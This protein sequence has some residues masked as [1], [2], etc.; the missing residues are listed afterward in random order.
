MGLSRRLRHFERKLKRDASTHE[1]R[2]LRIVFRRHRA[3]QPLWFRGDPNRIQR[4]ARNLLLQDA[5]RSHSESWTGIRPTAISACARSAPGERSRPSTSA[6][7]AGRD[8]RH[9]T[10]G[11]EIGY[12]PDSSRH[13][14]PVVKRRSVSRQGLVSHRSVLRSRRIQPVHPGIATQAMPE[15]KLTH[16][17]RKRSAAAESGAAEFRA[18]TPRSRV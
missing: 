6:K 10:A 1:D 17:S 2:L 12:T 13:T 8:P 15:F 4:R 3:G 5:Q 9:G 16:H 14:S 7:K 18:G 11:M